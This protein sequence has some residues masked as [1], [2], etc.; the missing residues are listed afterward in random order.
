MLDDELGK[1]F[2]FNLT[3]SPEANQ[4]IEFSW[5]EMEEKLKG[6]PDLIKKVILTNF[7]IGCRRPTP[8]NGYLEALVSPN[9]TTYTEDVQETTPTGF[10]D[11][12]GKDTKLM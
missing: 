6:R 5:R 4:A 3:N 8:G 11:N 9:V 10:I 2:N 12:E 1:R 7:G